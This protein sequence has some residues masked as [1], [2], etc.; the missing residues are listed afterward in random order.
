[1]LEAASAVGA[2]WVN[3]LFNAEGY[4]P[5]ATR[6]IEGEV[7]TRGE[8]VILDSLVVLDCSTARRRALSLSLL[9]ALQKSQADGGTVN[10]VAE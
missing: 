4:R 8:P 2:T 1:L 9:A 6:T 7:V 3:P 5:H 10:V